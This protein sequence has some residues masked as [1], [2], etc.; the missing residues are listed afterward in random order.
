[1]VGIKLTKMGNDTILLKKSSRSMYAHVRSQQLSVL[2]AKSR[3]I[4][5]VPE[6][7]QGGTSKVGLFQ[8]R[9]S[10]YPPSKNLVS[11]VIVSGEREEG[12]QTDSE[13]F[14]SEFF[15]ADDAIRRLTFEDDKGIAQ[16]ALTLVESH[17]VE[18]TT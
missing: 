11:A 13:D 6:H 3:I 5:D 10:D 14:R 18:R 15:E 8:L 9:P 2:L 4:E 1:M 16:R 7:S 12:T 17:A